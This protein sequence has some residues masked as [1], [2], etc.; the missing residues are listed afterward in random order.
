MFELVLLLFEELFS[1]S[2]SSK[3]RIFS[4]ASPPAA[5][6]IFAHCRLSVYVRRP[7][8]SIVGLAVLPTKRLTRFPLGTLEGFC[9][10]DLFFRCLP[11]HATENRAALTFPNQPPAL[12]SR[13]PSNFPRR[14]PNTTGDD[15]G[16]Q[17][18]TLEVSVGAR[19]AALFVHSYLSRRASA[20]F[21]VIT[22]EAT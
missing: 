1:K 2:A 10:S 21:S 22:A 11:Q 13:R 5:R 8:S 20:S 19:L 18:E 3:I 4:H 9:S 17:Q 12:V 6:S 7:E 14:G 16:G 15:V